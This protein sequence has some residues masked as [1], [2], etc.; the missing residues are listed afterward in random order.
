MNDLQIIFWNSRSLSNKLF[1]FKKYIY[2]RKPHI[3][4]IQESWLNDEYLPSFIN[5]RGYF[6]NRV[7]RA[8]GILILARNDL[9][10]E[11]INLQIFRNG[12][13]EIQGIKIKIYT[14]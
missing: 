1:E 6:K 7:G 13:L 10:T 3:V 12:K 2:T 9:I 8:G 11:D 4:C 14:D 5:Y